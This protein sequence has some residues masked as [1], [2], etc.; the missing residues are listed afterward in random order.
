VYLMFRCTG[1]L[2]A[3]SD[4]DDISSGLY[5]KFLFYNSVNLYFE[6]DDLLVAGL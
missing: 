1:Q 4:S 3:D 2:K 6:L 5:M